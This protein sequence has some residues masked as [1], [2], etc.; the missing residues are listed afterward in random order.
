M[1]GINKQTKAIAL[2]M[3]SIFIAAIMITVF[4]GNAAKKTA[5]ALSH[6]FIPFTAR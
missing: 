6:P 5:L 2:V 3:M 1:T 4:S